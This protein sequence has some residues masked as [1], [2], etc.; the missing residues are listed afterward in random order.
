MAVPLNNAP[1]FLI[2]KYAPDMRRM[3][4]RNIGV[5]AWSSGH[6]AA[7]FMGESGDSSTHKTPSFVSNKNKP[8]YL[9]WVGHWRR[10]LI[11]GSIAAPDGTPITKESS[12]F[13]A[14]FRSMGRNNYF[15]V[16]GGFLL[17]QVAPSELQDA[18]DQLYEKF[19]AD[20]KSESHEQAFVLL[21]QGWRSVLNRS[22][23][24]ARSDFRAH[25]PIECSIEGI[26]RELTFDN[27]LGNGSPE[28]VFQ[29]T[30]LHR[31]ESIISTYAMLEAVT[32]KQRILEKRR[33]AAIIHATADEAA[34]PTIDSAIRMLG[35]HGMV[36]NVALEDEAIEK[37]RSMGIPPAQDAAPS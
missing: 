35:L 5:I 34:Q 24:R 19:V 36:L 26:A 14:A 21:R 20:A 31:D 2:A 28:A 3:E 32:T 22:G 17:D 13:L 10:K 29:K 12:E 11:E 1:R 33:C 30:L 37:V 4:P 15:L 9:R 27:G 18:V 8:I 23:L 25:Y 6:I 7:R 16:D